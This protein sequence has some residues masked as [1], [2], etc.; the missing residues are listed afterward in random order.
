[1]RYPSKAEAVALIWNACGASDAQI[2]KELDCLPGAA[3][4]AL[5][6][7][8]DKANYFGVRISTQKKEPLKHGF[9][10]V[11]KIAKEAGLSRFTEAQQLAMEAGLIPR[12]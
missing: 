7:A 9:S 2:G 5:K 6:R 12:K 10:G 3:R 1:M 8:K 4:Q 11:Q